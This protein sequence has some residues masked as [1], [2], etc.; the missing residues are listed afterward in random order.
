MDKITEVFEQINILCDKYKDVTEDRYKVLKHAGVYDEYT[1]LICTLDDHIDFSSV[2]KEEIK[3]VLNIT[4]FNT[5]LPVIIR[6]E[7][8]ETTTRLTALIRYNMVYTKMVIGRKYV[9]SSMGNKFHNSVGEIVNEWWDAIPNK[10][11]EI[12]KI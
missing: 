9:D 11:I 6:D 12:V 8:K 2:I 1:N 4:D 3:E 5:A 7:T 10:V